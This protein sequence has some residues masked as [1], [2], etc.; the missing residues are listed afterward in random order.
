MS[1]VTEVQKRKQNLSVSHSSQSSQKSELL[2]EL[3][4]VNLNDNKWGS[5]PVGLYTI[6]PSHWPDPARPEVLGWR[7]PFPEGNINTA[8]H[9]SPNAEADE[10]AADLVLDRPAI[11]LTAALSGG[12]YNL[13]G[14]NKCGMAISKVLASLG[15]GQRV[16][17]ALVSSL[18]GSSDESRIGKVPVYDRST[19]VPHLDL[20]ASTWSEM[21]TEIVEDMMEELRTNSCRLLKN[22]HPSAALG[23][24]SLFSSPEDQ[25]VLGLYAW[26]R[27]SH[28]KV[29]EGTLDQIPRLEFDADRGG[30]MGLSLSP[31]EEKLFRSRAAPH[32]KPEEEVKRF[33]PLDLARLL[34]VLR[35]QFNWPDAKIRQRAQTM[36]GPGLLIRLLRDEMMASTPIWGGHPLLKLSPPL[37]PTSPRKDRAKRARGQSSSPTLQPVTDPE[38]TSGLQDETP[39]LFGLIE[40]IRSRRIGGRTEYRIRYDDVPLDHTIQALLAKMPSAQKD[41]GPPPIS[42]LRGK[43]A[44]QKLVPAESAPMAPSEDGIT[45]KP[46]ATPSYRSEPQLMWIDSHPLEN[47]WIGKKLVDQFH[48]KGRAK[49]AKESARALPRDQSKLLSITSKGT[50]STDPN[51]PS[52]ARRWERTS[53]SSSQI[54][55]QQAISGDSSRRTLSS[56]SGTSRLSQSIILQSSPFSSDEDC[57]LLRPGPVPARHRL[58]AGDLAA[59]LVSPQTKSVP[60]TFS[61][62]RSTPTP[63]AGGTNQ[64]SQR[65]EPTGH[66]AQSPDLTIIPNDNEDV[67]ESFFHDSADEDDRPV[68]DCPTPPRASSPPAQR[69]GG[70]NGSHQALPSALPTDFSQS[71][72]VA[73]PT[74]QVRPT[75]LSHLSARAMSRTAEAQPSLV[76]EPAVSRGQVVS[77]AQL[78]LPAWYHATS[79]RHRPSRNPP[80]AGQKQ[81]AKPQP[82]DTQRI[83]LDTSDDSGPSLLPSAQRPHNT[84]HCG[85]K[86]RNK[87]SQTDVVDLVSE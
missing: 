29:R 79:R 46:R 55:L 33:Q 73:V 35:I 86:E 28:L 77:S 12:D 13:Q 14:V 6:P 53:S 71:L 85:G 43:T 10:E 51:D 1:D 40:V 57:D 83:V 3:D 87:G 36:L 84:R 66:V 68:L 50:A 65:A 69:V 64:G 9:A 39:K 26:P 38:C 72:P 61:R 11:L 59:S 81:L 56:I 75:D 2:G 54:S 30:V 18:Q 82:Q 7:E 34:W 74:D 20:N 37:P 19:W 78:R 42:P 80:G 44:A 63:C 8:L 67:L 76:S 25:S 48:A 60:R 16:V 24:K 52:N 21:R 62:T 49:A 15:F 58:S 41:W 70:S 22:K 32:F 27:T 45:G 4:F 23:L 31:V 17:S 47:T 5:N